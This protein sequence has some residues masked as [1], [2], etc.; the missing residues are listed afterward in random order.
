[1]KPLTICGILVRDVPQV[2]EN[3]KVKFR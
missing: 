1:L 3:L 2:Q